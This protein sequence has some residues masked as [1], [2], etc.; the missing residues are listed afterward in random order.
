MKDIFNKDINIGEY[1]LKNYVNLTFDEKKLVL[2]HRNLNKKWM[3]QQDEITLENHLKWIEHLKND[4]SKLNYLVY[5]NNEPFIS[6]SYH[7]IKD[8][9]AY[10]GYFLINQDY[11]SEVLKIEKMIID[12]AFNNLKLNRLLCIND[13]ENHVVKIHKFFGF[14]EIEKKILNNKEYIVMA[15]KKDNI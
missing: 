3:L 11:K 9:E 13:S 4:N 8:D 7:D 12:F 14:K 1:Y 6:I 2:F 15:L 10:W 5:K